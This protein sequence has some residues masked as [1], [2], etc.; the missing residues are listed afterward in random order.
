MNKEELE[1]WQKIKEYFETLPEEKR[2]NQFYTRALAI[3]SGKPDPHE[4]PS[5]DTEDS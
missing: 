2:D 4:L 5:L 3:T 1:N